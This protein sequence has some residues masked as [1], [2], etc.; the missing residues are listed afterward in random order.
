MNKNLN[1]RER[2]EQKFEAQFQANEG[3]KLKKNKNKTNDAVSLLN[4]S[5]NR[6]NPLKNTALKPIQCLRKKLKKKLEKK[7]DLSQPELTRKTYDPKH[8]I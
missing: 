1:H 5:W 2:S 4:L 6:N 7:K 3:T 8:D